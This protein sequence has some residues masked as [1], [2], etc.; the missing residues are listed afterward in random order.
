MNS[1][2]VANTSQLMYLA[3]VSILLSNRSIIAFLGN[4]TTVAAW[5]CGLRD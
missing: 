2:E 5:R 3:D 4:N 1:R